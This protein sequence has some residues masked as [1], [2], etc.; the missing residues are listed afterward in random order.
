MQKTL[1]AWA[2]NSLGDQDTGVQSQDSKSYLILR[3]GFL[4]GKKKYVVLTVGYLSSRWIL[5]RAKKDDTD[6][7]IAKYDG[8]SN[9][10]FGWQIFLMSFVIPEEEVQAFGFCFPVK[11]VFTEENGRSAY[12]P[13]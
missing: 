6:D 11:I 4:V 3:A 2:Q 9:S 5:S 7:E 1:Q 10:G 13:G 8:K 12:I